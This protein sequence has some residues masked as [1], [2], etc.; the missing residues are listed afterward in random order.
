MSNAGHRLAKEEEW[1]LSAVARLRAGV[2]A[3]V[4]GMFA[5]TGLLVATAWLVIRGGDRVGEH[6]GLLRNYLP[7]Y[8]VTWSGALLGFVY[9]L[10]IGGAAGWL[11]AWIY[12]RIA[13]VRNSRSG[14]NGGA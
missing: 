14:S 6:L 4:C 10:L 1:I 9:G 5:G 8:S 2:M 12:N 7:G 13:A 3:I 11:T